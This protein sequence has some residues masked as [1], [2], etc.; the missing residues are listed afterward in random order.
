ML[1]HVHK[2]IHRDIKP[3]N[4]LRTADGTIKF[5]DFGL[6][7]FFNEKD[8]TIKDT[9]K[10]CR[11][12][13][14]RAFKAPEHVR[15]PSSPYTTATD[16]WALGVTLYLM[17]FGK[18][19][20]DGDHCEKRLDK[21]ILEEDFADLPNEN[22]LLLALLKKLLEKDPN[23]RITLERLRVRPIPP[24]YIYY[25]FTRYILTSVLN[26]EFLLVYI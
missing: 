17:L 8:E 3:A 14:S 18:L 26:T 10:P 24:F 20:F 2:I 22:P 12:A 7:I 19:P 1:V 21:A 5:A 15:D 13:G 4:I 9:T 23:K 6:S 11:W 25:L 16:I